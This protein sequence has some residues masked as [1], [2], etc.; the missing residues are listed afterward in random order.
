MKIKKV[1]IEELPHSKSG[2]QILWRDCIGYKIRFIYDDIEGWLEIVNVKREK[3]DSIL[4]LKYLNRTFKMLTNNFVKCKYGKMLGKYAS[5]FKIEIDTRFQ[6]DKRDITIIDR[7]IRKANRTDKKNENRKWYKY[8]CNVC[9]WTEGWIEES[10]I[11]KGIGC[12][13]C[14]NQI[15]VQGINDIP[16]TNPEMINYFQGGYDEAKL[17]TKC[18]GGN[19]NNPKGYIYPICPNCKEVRKNK[20][21]IV[22]IYVNHSISCKKC[23]K[24]IS[25]PNKFAFNMLEQLGI[26]FIPEYSPEWIGQKRYD[27]YFKLDNKEYILEMDGGWHIKDNTKSGQTKEKSQAID[28]YKDEQARF[29]DIDVIRIDCDYGGYDKFEFIK[30]NTLNS[31]LNKLF[32]LSMIDWN[33][34]NEFALSSRVK[35]ACDLKRN[36]PN[37]TIRDISELMRL[38]KTT[39][40]T[41]LYKGT[42]YGWC[43]Y[44]P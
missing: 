19:P 14:A 21:K 7:E 31:K 43:V 35:E 33:K 12:S 26:N 25:Y 42:E 22:D 30:R 40:R 34:I 13:C 11:L 3:N 41:Y 17:Y 27:F 10:N 32:D 38:S 23:G 18:G 24:G 28:N 39:I 20:I 6:D 5:D 44:V 4:Y 1:F 37:L 8:T 36:N 15:V 29:H 16:T 2:K 9:G